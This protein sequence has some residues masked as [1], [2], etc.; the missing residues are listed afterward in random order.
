MNIFNREVNEKL[1]QQKYIIK[2]VRKIFP[3]IVTM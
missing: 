2:N 3:N 1:H